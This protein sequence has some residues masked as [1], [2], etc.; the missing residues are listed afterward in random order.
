MGGG[1]FVGS[2]LSTLSG[3]SLSRLARTA[4]AGAAAGST[5]ASDEASIGLRL[6]DV[7]ANHAMHVPMEAAA[8]AIGVVAASTLTNGVLIVRP[9]PERVQ[10]VL[11]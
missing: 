1:V 10:A 2:R 7:L 4:A 11:E 3:L 8:S 5:E 9:V 6:R